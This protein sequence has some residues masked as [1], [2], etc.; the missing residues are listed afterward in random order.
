MVRGPFWSAAHSQANDLH[1]LRTY[2]GRYVRSAVHTLA[3]PDPFGE[4]YCC[5]NT[6]QGSPQQ[7]PKQSMVQNCEFAVASSDEQRGGKK[8]FQRSSQ[9]PPPTDVWKDEDLVVVLADD[10]NEYSMSDDVLGKWLS[11]GNGNG[12][13]GDKG[14]GKGGDKGGD[15]GGGK[16]GGNG[17]GNGGGE[18]N[19]DGRGDGGGKGNSGKGKTNV[20]TFEP[21]P[22]DVLHFHPSK[23]HAFYNSFP[24]GDVVNAKYYQIDLDGPITVLQTSSKALDTDHPWH[25]PRRQK[26]V[27]V[28]FKTGSGHIAWTNFSRN[29]VLWLRFPG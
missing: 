12:H 10:A 27:S 20:G 22:G 29:G 8:K 28:S 15:K 4:P 5:E 16:G 21:L 26:F 2:V 14:G 18:G 25:G 24:D 23:D 9:Q 13:G 19:G 1:P 7:P 3:M 17:G 11:C 6:P